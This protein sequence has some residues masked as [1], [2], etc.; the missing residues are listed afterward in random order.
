MKMPR[1]TLKTPRSLASPS[2]PEKNIC[3][4]NA[5][6][7]YCGKYSTNTNVCQFVFF[8]D[9]AKTILLF[10]RLARLSRSNHDQSA[11]ARA[12]SKYH[13]TLAYTRAPLATTTSYTPVKFEYGS[14]D[15]LKGASRFV[16]DMFAVFDAPTALFRLQH[17][18][19]EGVRSTVEIWEQQT[20]HVAYSPF[21]SP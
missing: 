15:E 2:Q 19:Y 3:S 21:F 7:T 10:G 14:K 6:S 20:C 12:P 11:F 1:L 5:G 16:V 9:S 13:T 17:S 4:V 18:R 8:P